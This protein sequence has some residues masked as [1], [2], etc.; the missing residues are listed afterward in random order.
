MK[1][2]L[3]G[4]NAHYT[5][6]TLEAFLSAQSALGLECIELY[7]MPPHVW[8]DHNGAREL[9]ELARSIKVSGLRVA[10]LTPEQHSGK[11]AICTPDSQHWQ[12]TKD[13]FQ[14]SIE[15]A[16]LLGAKIL[17]IWPAGLLRG[18]HPADMAA[19]TAQRL[20]QLA[21]FAEKAGVQIT[22]G[23]GGAALCPV[24]WISAVVSRCPQSVGV[25]LD[26]VS[27]GENG[28]SIAQWVTALGSRINC[29]RLCDGRTGAQRLVWGKG[30]YPLAGY[31][32]ELTAHRIQGPLLL[33]MDTPPYPTDPAAA[34]AENL[35]AILRT[36]EVET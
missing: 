26:T 33:G 12:R 32:H 10:V 23:P 29:T 8:I 22:F 36:V 35:A 16:A 6:C 1:R 31:L 3:V 27:M 30:V 5:Y 4:T 11:Y 13:Y 9:P 28:E 14:Q 24:S 34:D 2:Q 20:E 7:A 19:L 15:A 18:T 17:S 25:T 21:A